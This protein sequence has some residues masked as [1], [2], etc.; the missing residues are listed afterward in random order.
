M[1]FKLYK[2]TEF[3]PTEIFNPVKRIKV[4][5]VPEPHGDGFMVEVEDMEAASS[6]IKDFG[7]LLVSPEVPTQFPQ[8]PNFEGDFLASRFK[9][10]PATEAEIRDGRY[11]EPYELFQDKEDVLAKEEEDLGP[12]AYEA[13]C[14][15]IREKLNAAG[16]K[17]HPA[18]KLD[19]LRK[20]LAETA[21]E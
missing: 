19:K 3:P 8:V 16:V 4:P 5:V 17:F 20:K 15:E 13:A 11:H 14:E 9:F 12:E 7:F 1:K 18:T 10:K 6:A 2:K 21:G